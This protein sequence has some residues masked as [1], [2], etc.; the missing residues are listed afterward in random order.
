MLVIYKAEFPNGKVYI[1]KSKN[2]EKRK[3]HHIW[4]STREKNNHII[5]SKAIR[6]YGVDN[7]KWEII[8]ECCDIDDMNKKEIE[9]IKLYNSTSHEFG[10]NMVCGDKEG[11][12]K[13]E[14]FDKD[15]QIDIILRKLESNGHDSKKYIVITE[16]LKKTF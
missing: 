10:Y 7:I 3:Y 4:N 11:F 16:Q 14:N 2:F 5:M 9:Y 13:R 12:S 15:Y 6:K 8:C 1:G